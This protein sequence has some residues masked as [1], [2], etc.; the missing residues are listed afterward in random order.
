MSFGPSKRLSEFL[1]T[2]FEF[3]P[4]QL[5]L[6]VWRGKINMHN[7]LFKKAAFDPLLKKCKSKPNISVH[8]FMSKAHLVDEN[9][10]DCSFLDLKLVSGNIG[11]L[12]VKVPWQS[13]LV[14][15]SEKVEVV[16]KDVVIRLAVESSMSSELQKRD[17]ALRGIYEESKPNDANVLSILERKWKEKMIE[18]AMK[19]LEDGKDIPS[20]QEFENLKVEFIEEEE[21]CE[22]DTVIG[23]HRS[24]M[25]RF[26]GSF[27]STL[28]WRVGKDLKLSIEN[29]KIIM[30]Q[31]NV[32]L[33]LH[34]SRIDIGEDVIQ[35]VDASEDFSSVTTSQNSKM[36]EE[37][38]LVSDTMKKCLIISKL[39]IFV[40][41]AKSYEGYNSVPD[42]KVFIFKPTNAKMNMCL[43]R[44]GDKVKVEIDNE[45]SS[46]SFHNNDE[47]D[48]M[49]F[50]EERKEEE[51]KVQRRGKREKR[52]RNDGSNDT[53]VE[54]VNDKDEDIPDAK[55]RSFISP[56]KQDKDISQKSGM[57]NEVPSSP[58][59]V[60]ADSFGG[61]QEFSNVSALFSLQVQVESVHVV[62]TLHTMQLCQR[63]LSRVKSIE[64]GRPRGSLAENPMGSEQRKI[65]LRQMMH[66][67][68]LQVLKDFRK[69]RLVQNYFARGGESGRLSYSDEYIK[70]SELI[71][72]DKKITSP[73]EYEQSIAKTNR[74]KMKRLEGWL[75]VEQVVLY[76]KQYQ[77]EI[78]NK[79]F[80]PFK[81]FS[82]VQRS[83]SA[84]KSTTT[85]RHRHRPSRIFQSGS[86]TSSQIPKHQKHKTLNV[87]TMN[88]V[89]D[90]IPS[91]RHSVY[92]VD[93][94]NPSLL[95][96]RLLIP[97]MPDVEQLERMTS[98]RALETT[99]QYSDPLFDAPANL[100]VSS[101][102]SVTVS[103]LHMNLYEIHG[104]LGKMVEDGSNESRLLISC[105]ISRLLFLDTKS[106]D[107]IQTFSI[108]SFLLRS[109]DSTILH[110]G[111]FTDKDESSDSFCIE[112]TISSDSFGSSS[113]FLVG[114]ITNRLEK[115]GQEHKKKFRLRFAKVQC[116]FDYGT[117]VNVVDFFG[118]LRKQACGDFANPSDFDKMRYV[119]SKSLREPMST[120]SAQD[121]VLQCGGFDLHVTVGPEKESS[122]LCAIGNLEY[123]Q[124]YSIN[125]CDT[126]VEQV[127]KWNYLF[128][129]YIS[130]RLT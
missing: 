89:L 54:N 29:L 5:K 21:N 77:N 41:E 96:D 124:G 98:G 85:K 8:E 44:T 48:K 45:E 40:K 119:A 86:I 43:R 6:G 83:P 93:E 72:N 24:F 70:L 66:Y 114:K 82:P 30:V 118:I 87:E 122:V 91:E 20:P 110:S 100:S 57:L 104:S 4:N 105:V 25:E 31:D 51:P 103:S 64:R 9:I 14:G 84:R 52:R 27:A 102:I 46:M 88:E 35:D 106:N 68:V 63:F 56:S 49:E 113:P 76:R 74:Q 59:C 112:S 39:G 50:E 128:T 121:L 94:E 99:E 32:E 15:G 19:C 123:K 81:S 109:K 69:K 23:E 36:S 7:L 58:P 111:N 130:L 18:I 47:D 115:Y 16:L 117:C 11:H 116:W 34:V 13:L 79:R 3:E 97:S 61:I 2:Y 26:V 60:Q 53:A 62:A 95:Q 120:Q 107:R 78:S 127:S 12:D 65:F 17:N 33:G 10:S 22:E 125:R 101:S 129:T 75:S 126:Q 71:K 42:A 108:S 37:K 55:K 92:V 1:S 38:H 80:N 90:L 67:T 28:G 73:T